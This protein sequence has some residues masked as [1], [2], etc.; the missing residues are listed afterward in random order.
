MK[1]LYFQ[2]MIEVADINDIPG[3]V[4]LINSAYR[5]DASRKGWTTEADLLEGEL[6]TDA[7]S[8]NE[9][10][11]KPGSRFLKFTDDG[12]LQGCVHL[13]KQGEEMYLGMLSVSPDAQAKGVGKKFLAAAEEYAGKTG[14]SSIIMNVISV[15]HEL[16]NWYERHGYTR[17]GETKPFPVDTKFG[18]PKQPLEFIVLK[19]NLS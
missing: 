9:L 16:I 1:F 8:L 2:F 3:L 11:S 10:M 13:Q 7:A 14:C 12:V 5:G 18:T 19:K 4:R 17:T 15:R 6:R